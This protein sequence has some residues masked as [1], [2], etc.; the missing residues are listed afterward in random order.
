MYCAI[1]IERHST[2]GHCLHGASCA[3]RFCSPAARYSPEPGDTIRIPIEC[4][5][6]C[7]AAAE[8]HYTH[9]A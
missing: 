8:A 1:D 9:D 3:R 7:G 6:E 5:A 2:G 4:S